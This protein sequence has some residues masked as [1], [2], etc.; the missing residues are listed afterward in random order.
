MVI[1][2]DGVAPTQKKSVEKE[3]KAFLDACPNIKLT[4]LI[5]NK[6]T[7]VKV[8]LEEANGFRNIPPGTL[9]DNSIVDKNKFEFFLISQKSNQGLPQPTHYEVIYDDNSCRAEDLHLFAYKMCYLYYNWTGS[10]KIPSACQYAKKLA[11]LVGDKLSTKGEIIVPG[12]RFNTQTRS[13]YFL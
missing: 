2:R 4:F 12:E 10:I 3:I 1:I 6:K 13:L 9:V 8:F 5:L 7:A 11:F